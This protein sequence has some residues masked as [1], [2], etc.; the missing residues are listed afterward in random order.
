MLK[1]GLDDV[2]FRKLELLQ[3]V[4]TGVEK[5]EERERVTPFLRC[6]ARRGIIRHLM[7]CRKSCSNQSQGRYNDRVSSI[8][9]RYSS[10][11]GKIF[12]CK[13]ME[14]KSRLTM[15]N[16]GDSGV[17]SVHGRISKVQ[18]G[19]EAAATDKS[20]LSNDDKDNGSNITTA[21]CSAALPLHRPPFAA[22]SLPTHVLSPR[23]INYPHI[24]K[25]IDNALQ[26]SRG[27]KVTLP[28]R[29]L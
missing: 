24:L 7:E 1:S 12:A 27:S 28:L 6:N 22:M 21:N 19:H 23:P 4:L 9:S 16:D 15:N 20:F 10:R 13:N 2:S 3:P 29:S 5:A 14:W 17:W 18:D 11:R 26:D 8:G 25:D